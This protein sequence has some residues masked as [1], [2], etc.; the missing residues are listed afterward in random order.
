MNVS[1]SRYAVDASALVYGWGEPDSEGTPIGRGTAILAVDLSAHSSCRMR[2]ECVLR[3]GCSNP[4]DSTQIRVFINEIPAA[5][6]EVGGQETGSH[7]LT[8][9]PAMMQTERSTYIRFEAGTPLPV[10]SSLSLHR[11]H[12]MPLVL[13][14]SDVFECPPGERIQF[15][16]DPRADELLGDGWAGQNQDGVWSDG[17]ES[18]LLLNPLQ[19]YV[20][21]SVQFQLGPRHLGSWPADQQLLV[22]VNGRHAAQLDLRT[23]QTPTIEIVPEDLVHRPWLEFR[24][25]P[26]PLAFTRYLA[27]SG[28]GTKL[29]QAILDVTFAN[30]SCGVFQVAAALSL[31]DQAITEELIRQTWSRYDLVTFQKRLK[32]VAANAAFTKLL[33]PLAPRN[34]EGQNTL[35]AH[36]ARPQFMLRSVSLRANRGADSWSA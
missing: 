18:E 28:M 20:P 2:M 22:V 13:Q 25:I 14:Q 36:P 30:P 27:A 17:Y 11:L 32:A 12:F 5:V 10:E 19:G 16:N 3:Y 15:G 4:L 33:A 26:A 31:A 34:G 7:S 29:D 8:V 23:N 24:F 6:W 1:L 9:W 21:A 35:Q